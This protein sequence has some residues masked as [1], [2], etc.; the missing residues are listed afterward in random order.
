VCATQVTIDVQFRINL[1]YAVDSKNE[2]FSLD[3]FVRELW[4]DERLAFDERLWPDSLGALRIPASRPIWRPDTFFQNA[5]SCASSDNLLTLNATGKLNWSRHQ[6]CVFNADFNLLEFPFESV[7]DTAAQLETQIR[8]R[9]CSSGSRNKT[10]MLIR[11]FSYLL[12]LFVTVLKP[13]AS[14]ASRT[15]T[16]N[17]SW[18]Y[19]FTPIFR[20]SVTLSPFLAF[21]FCVFDDHFFIL[22]SHTKLFCALSLSITLD[23]I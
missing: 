7:M 21:L 11:R 10:Q 9:A 16:Q 15:R 17:Q 19:V 23:S 2:Q 18:W 8:A 1:L 6:T 4:T 12:R 13:S 5:V 22:A 20:C 3:F 14:S